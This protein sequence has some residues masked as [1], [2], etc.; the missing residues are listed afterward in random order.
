MLSDPAQMIWDLSVL[1]ISE[2][3]CLLHGELL[4]QKLQTV[5]MRFG[6]TMC[7]CLEPLILIFV[8]KNRRH[9]CC[10]DAKRVFLFCY[11]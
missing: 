7:F 3:I 6:R 9:F 5:D 2:R 8:F 11:S 10:L 1:T 4:D